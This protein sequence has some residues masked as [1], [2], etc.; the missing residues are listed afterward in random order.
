MLTA[1]A[2]AYGFSVYKTTE[3][4][5][6]DAKNMPLPTPKAVRFLIHALDIL[7]EKEPVLDL[8]ND[9]HTAMSPLVQLHGAYNILLKA[10]DLHF[11]Y[12]GYCG[13][14]QNRR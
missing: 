4:A 3:I 14:I 13:I 8:G 6:H 10:P 12:N 7:D 9:T 11:H 2:L 5:V 1:M